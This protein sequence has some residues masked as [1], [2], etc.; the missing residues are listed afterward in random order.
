MNINLIVIINIYKFIY[1]VYF[2]IE[3]KL[4]YYLQ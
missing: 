3:L 4:L 2:T 1:I